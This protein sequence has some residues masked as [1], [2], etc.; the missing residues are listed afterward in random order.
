MGPLRGRISWSRCDVID[1]REFVAFVLAVFVRAS[2]PA[3]TKGCVRTSR[4]TVKRSI[5]PVGSE[6]FA[7]AERER[8]LDGMYGVRAVVVGMTHIVDDV[9]VWE[10]QHDADPNI[11]WIG[12]EVHG[13]IAVVERSAP[14]DLV[15]QVIKRWRSG[16]FYWQRGEATVLPEALRAISPFVC[17]LAEDPLVQIRT[18]LRKFRLQEGA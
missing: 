13:H 18:G 7:L 11:F 5:V 3:I 16:D 12:E 14:Q 6:V 8:S 4:Y 1:R 15:D 2:A 17:E 9:W 10:V